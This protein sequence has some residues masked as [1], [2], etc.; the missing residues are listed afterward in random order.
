MERDRRFRLVV[1][2]LTTLLAGGSCHS[3]VPS[4]ASKE[5]GG[6]NAPD[7][8]ERARKS[9]RHVWTGPPPADLDDTW[10]VAPDGDALA[11]RD[12]HS[13]L[14]VRDFRAGRVRVLADTLPAV[15]SRTRMVWSPDASHLAY[16]RNV[17]ANESELRIVPLAGGA[18]RVIL[19]R[20]AY[21]APLA[22]SPD[23]ARILALIENGS[24]DELAWVTVEAGRTETVVQLEGAYRN[25]WHPKA[26]LSPDGKQLAFAKVD[27]TVLGADSTAHSQRR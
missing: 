20:K 3:S 23:A 17:T 26:I 2:A 8:A 19:R 5:Q 25:E 22:W 16:N 14:A 24:K 10:A 15:Q 13:R 4:E 11:F 6:L 9:L 12:E 21:L 27:H 1:L 7:G 18:P